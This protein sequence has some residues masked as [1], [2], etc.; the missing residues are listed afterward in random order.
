MAFDII[1]KYTDEEAERVIAHVGKRSRYLED[2]LHDFITYPNLEYIRV[3]R[4]PK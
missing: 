1:A 2:I 4:S 3:E